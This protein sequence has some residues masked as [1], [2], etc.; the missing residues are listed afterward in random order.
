MGLKERRREQSFNPRK[1]KLL[2]Y[3]FVV[4]RVN[5]CGHCV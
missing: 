3:L 2:E 1:E 4:I 5:D